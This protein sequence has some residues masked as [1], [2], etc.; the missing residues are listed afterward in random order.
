MHCFSTVWGLVTQGPTSSYTWK[1]V[2]ETINA[3]SEE[4]LLIFYL[5]SQGKILWGSWHLS[6]PSR[7]GPVCSFV[8]N[9]TK[10]PPFKLSA[11][12]NSPLPG[13]IHY[14]LLFF[15]SPYVLVLFNY[16][17]AQREDG[18]EALCGRR[19]E[20]WTGWAWAGNR[21]QFRLTEVQDKCRLQRDGACSAGK[22]LLWGWRLKSGRFFCN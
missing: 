12:E 19:R 7:A 15:G 2:M 5:D 14:F 21:T 17:V 8:T 18:M 16:G 9:D 4:T 6:W 13:A 11:W 10:C 3:S 20:R 22:S 1:T